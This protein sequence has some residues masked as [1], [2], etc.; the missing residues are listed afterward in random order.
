MLTCAADSTI[1]RALPI[2]LPSIHFIPQDG[3]DYGVK[4]FLESKF[5][6]VYITTLEV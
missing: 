4:S 3:G 2:T 5:V 1:V 6:V